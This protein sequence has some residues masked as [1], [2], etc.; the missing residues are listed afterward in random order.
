M[1]EGKAPFPSAAA[2]RETAGGTAVAVAAARHHRPLRR[3]PHQQQEK[4]CHRRA[5][6]NNSGYVPL[7]VF[8]P[9]R[10]AERRWPAAANFLL[11]TVGVHRRV[12]IV[13]PCDASLGCPLVVL[14]R[15]QAGRLMSASSRSERAQPADHHHHH[16]DQQVLL[17]DEHDDNCFLLY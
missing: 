15:V 14:L 2:A 5:S 7:Y 16:H 17:P 8:G 3:P 1:G 9:A 6:I 4:A 12:I 11:T 13:G 10:G